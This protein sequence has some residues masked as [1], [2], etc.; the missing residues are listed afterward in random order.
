MEQYKRLNDI[1]NPKRSDMRAVCDWL[2]SMNGGA[3]FLTGDVEDVWTTRNTAGDIIPRSPEDF[4]GFE[5]DHGIA[6]VSGGSL[7]GYG[8]SS[9]LAALSDNH[10]TLIRLDLVAWVKYCLRSLHVYF[11]SYPLSYSISSS[12][13]YSES[14]PYSFSRRFWRR[15]W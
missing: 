8:D 3:S 10:I 15:C 12:D 6:V 14:A 9:P 1:G 11:L 5:E 13:S 2:N 7:P 4:Y